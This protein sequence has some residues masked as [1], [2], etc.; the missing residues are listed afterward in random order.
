MTT[1]HLFFSERQEEF[2]ELPPAYASVNGRI[3]RISERRDVEDGTIPT[4]NFSD[5]IYLGVEDSYQSL[6]KRLAIDEDAH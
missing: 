6:A 1:T 3:V 5:A 2:C 4:S